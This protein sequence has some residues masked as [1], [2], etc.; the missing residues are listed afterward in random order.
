MSLLEIVHLTWFIELWSRGGGFGI[1]W[2]GLACARMRLVIGTRATIAPVFPPNNHK[3]GGS[4]FVPRLA[5]RWGNCT[6]S[7]YL[8]AL[9]EILFFSIASNH[10]MESCFMQNWMFELKK[11]IE[12]N[13]WFE[14]CS[15][16]WW[17]S[18]SFLFVQVRK[19]LKASAAPST[20]FPHSHCPKDRT[21]HLAPSS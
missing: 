2:S 17:V 10:I 3:T 14:F 9:I 19:T 12:K 13:K 4:P 1:N 6:A 16:V 21:L 15:T 11:G 8:G 20:F 7:D 5:L 18:G